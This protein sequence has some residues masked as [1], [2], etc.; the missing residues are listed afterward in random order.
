MVVPL[1]TMSLFAS[2]AV[3]GART[4]IPACS[5]IG[6]SSAAGGKK[7]GSVR[8]GARQPSG[9]GSPIEKN[10]ATHTAKG[11]CSPAAVNQTS[12]VVERRPTFTSRDSA[13]NAGTDVVR[14]TCRLRS[15]VGVERPKASDAGKPTETSP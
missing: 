2:S 4:T 12:P 1:V 13:V 11:S 3:P 5:S 14:N 9:S 6:R 8:S 7:R 10:V 15:R